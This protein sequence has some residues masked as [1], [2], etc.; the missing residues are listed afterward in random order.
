VSPR[1]PAPAGLP[2]GG[3][4]PLARWIQVLCGLFAALLLV[5]AAVIWTTTDYLWFRKLG[6]AEV[7]RVSYGVRW[8]MFGVAGGFVA[9]VTG[10]SAALAR[11]L[12]PPQP[13]QP[14]QPFQPAQP[15]LLPDLL[16]PSRL[17]RT[18]MAVDQNWGRLLGG[19]LLLTGVLAGL[20]GSRSWATWVQFA[21]RTSFGRRDPQFHLDISFFV[22]VY[23]FLRLVLAFLFVAVL[24]ALAAATAV[25]VLYGGLRFRPGDTQV[26]PAARAQL[27]GLLGFFMLLKAAAYWLD[28][29]GIES[30]AHDVIS[31]GASYTAVHA[32]LPAKTTLAVIAVLCAGLFFAA[33]AA[34]RHDP[35]L[36]TVGL[37]LLVLSAVLLG[38]VYPAVVEQFSVKPH[39]LARET[40]YLERQLSSTRL[41][42]GLTRVRVT[43]WPPG[44]PPAGR[45]P[46]GRPPAGPPAPS[47]RPVLASLQSGIPRSAVVPLPPGLRRHAH[48]WPG[49]RRYL[50]APLVRVAKLAPFLTLDGNVYPVVVGGQLDWVVDGYTT[51]DRYPAAAGF[52][53]TAAAA[54]SPA[55]QGPGRGRVDYVRDS[56]KAVVQAESGRVTLYQWDTADP[57]L[58]TWM[59]A[60]PGLIVPRRAMP[61][62][63]RAHLR[64]PVDLFDLQREVLASYHVGTAA[65]FYRGRHAWTVAGGRPVSLNLTLPG[66]R[67]R[68][69]SRTATYT[70]TDG[71][72]LAAFLTVASDP[73]R[74]G[75]GTL[76]LLELPPGA[77]VAG[78][79]QVEAGFRS[80]PVTAAAV[81]RLRHRGTRLIPGPL[82]TLPAGHG[83]LYAE[84]VYA[85]RPGRPPL[86]ETVLLSYGGRVAAGPTTKA[87]LA[88]LTRSAP[89]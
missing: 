63:L 67:V 73:A 6:F 33:A 54:G 89:R 23:P 34:A 9:L 68:E 46:A 72:T 10:F 4:R 36:P 19:T 66:S 43:T 56:V 12:P 44:R 52:D 39:E 25:H 62:A 60:E 29:Y 59:K 37:G 77:A 71:T 13:A 47:L 81:A 86:L 57:I 16:A 79:A 3:P 26:T 40:P 51:T 41:A 15:L 58:R 80:D 84:P 76:R 2:V 18:R 24:L 35:L 1:P 78:P 64:Y 14:S 85:A 17:A 53:L 70:R 31:G 5:A 87:A 82:V 69:S 38:G 45:P 20:A 30:S 32:V 75:Y 74:P 48:F 88:A 49:R 22:F 61:R 83:F 8:A 65:A 27:F 50:G 7:F 11:A 55:P 21:H 28:R 42:F